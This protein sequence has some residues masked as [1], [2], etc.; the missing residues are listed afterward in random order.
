MEL[1]KVNGDILGAIAAEE[2]T[3]GRMVV[4][5][6]HAFN[7]D[8]GS[9]TDL[10]AV[11]LPSTADEGKRARFM[12]GWAVD[13]RTPPYFVPTPSYAFS[14]RTGG[15]GGAANVPFSATVWLTYPG[16]Q[17]D[18]AIPSGTTCLAYGAG[19]YTLSS[20][21]YIYAAAIKVPGCLLSVA[22]AD[23]NRGKVQSQATFDA[24]VVVG[25]VVEYNTTTGN[26]TITT[27]DF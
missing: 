7:N 15:F 14:L 24:D 1:N 6:S 12:I 9:Q 22:Y 21:Q 19:T 27:M 5:T 2:I 3:E 10:P 8:F 18:K 25:K 11:K 17:L 20:G 26:L 23:P 4:L 16:M 13:N